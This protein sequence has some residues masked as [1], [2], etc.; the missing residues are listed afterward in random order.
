[1]FCVIVIELRTTYEKL[2]LKIEKNNALRKV[3]Q[4]TPKTENQGI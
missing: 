1:M 3:E 4:S 2:V